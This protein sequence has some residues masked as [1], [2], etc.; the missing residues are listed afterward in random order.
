MTE[1]ASPDPQGPFPKTGAGAISDSELIAL[2]RAG[3]SA[4]YEELFL[5]HREVAIRFARRLSD[6]ERAEDLCAEAFTKILDLLQRGK[7]PEVSFRAYLLTTV[8]TSHL[9]D[10]RTGNREVLVPDHEPIGRMMPVVE[11]PDGRFERGAIC[12]AFYQLPERWQ[13]ILWLTSVEGYSHEQVGEHLGIKASAVASLA[14]RARGG[15][16][17]AY[18]AEHIHDTSDPACLAILSQLPSYAR[19]RL[20]PRRRRLVEQH[21]DTC[22]SCTRAALEL[23]EVD[24]SL[25]A[26]LAPLALTGFAAAGTGLGG[27]AGI[28]TLVTQAKTWGSALAGTLGTKTAAV[29]TVTALSL[30]VGAE[31]ILQNDPEQTPGAEE[32]TA[33]VTSILLGPVIGKRSTRPLPVPTTPTAPAAPTPPGP[34]IHPGFGWVPPSPNLVTPTVQPAAPPSATSTPTASESSTP[35]RNTTRTMAIG[36]ASDQ[37]YKKDGFWWE[38]VL[39]PV[40]APVEGA[41]LEVLTT[42]TIQAT[43]ATTSGTGWVCGVPTTQWAFGTPYTT[44]RIRCIYDTVGNG[45]PLRFDYKVATGSTMTAVLTPPAGYVDSSLLDNV[46]T[47][48]LKD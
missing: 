24:R 5:R 12:R 47:L 25:G 23:S 9:N 31:V 44:T 4:A 48:V 20:S 27:G 35:P 10:L 1:V 16:R 30:G 32:P 26:L 43:T 28:T 18:L 40:I 19:D 14:F 6:T 36:S 34:T 11:D 39:V 7:G 42:R 46:L 21:L 15:L 37:S 38:Q 22:A 41:T 45:E 17:Q 13:T 33:E 8:R 3:D 2:V 29:A